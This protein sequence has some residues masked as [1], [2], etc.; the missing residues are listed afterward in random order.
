MIDRQALQIRIEQD[1]TALMSAHRDLLHRLNCEL[2]L[3]R[4]LQDRGIHL[5]PADLQRLITAIR[6]A[7]PAY[8]ISGESRYRLRVRLDGERYVV[9]WDSALDCIVTIWRQR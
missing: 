4:R 8:Q 7:R 1:A 9:V 5:S 6:K 2:H 3:F